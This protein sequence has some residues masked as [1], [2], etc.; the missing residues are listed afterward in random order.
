MADI[1][2][3][4][5]SGSD[6]TINEITAYRIVIT[7][8][9]VTAF[10]GNPV[11]PQPSVHRVI[12]DNEQYPPGGIQDTNDR[13]FFFYLDEVMAVPPGEESAVD[14][15]SANLLSIL[16]YNSDDRYIRQ[17]KDIPFFICGSNSHA[18]TDVCVVDRQLGILLLVQEDKRHMEAKSPE[19]QLMAEAIAA[20]QSNN[21]RLETLGQARLA[22]KIIPGITM[23]GSVPTFY[24]IHVKQALVD[25]VQ[26]GAYP[27]AVTTVHKLVPPVADINQLGRQGMRPLNNRAVI[28]GCFEAFK[29]F[30]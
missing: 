4:A 26:T 20:F 6:W 30:I 13:M 21:Q 17:R 15:F 14:D 22:E 11:L 2:R 5:K 10:F 25:A 28:L 9:N 8:Q 16:Q 19:P 23:V 1:I 24:K 7:P 3:S 27:T 12:L 29:R 18:K